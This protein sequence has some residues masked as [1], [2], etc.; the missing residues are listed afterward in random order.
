MRFPRRSL[1]G[2]LLGVGVGQVEGWGLGAESGARRPQALLLAEGWWKGVVKLPAGAAEFLMEVRGSELGAAE[3]ILHSETST[4]RLDLLTQR[5]AERELVVYGDEVG[6]ALEGRVRNGAWFGRYRVK[7]VGG[8]EGTG[9]TAAGEGGQSYAFWAQ[10]AAAWETR[11]GA[12]VWNLSGAWEMRVGPLEAREVHFAHLGDRVRVFWREAGGVVR[13][14]TGRLEGKWFNLE[15]RRS[16]AVLRGRYEEGGVLRG[17][18][19]DGAGAVQ[20]FEMRRRPVVSG[21]M[22]LALGR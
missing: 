1:L 14:A 17:T 11:P 3:V 19:E 16:G 9:A 12:R 4:V 8:G 2:L 15:G 13:Y 22:T 10:P 21:S 7:A 6:E 18:Y 5:E 20:E